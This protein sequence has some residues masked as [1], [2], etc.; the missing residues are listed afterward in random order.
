[1]PVPQRVE[2]V[3]SPPLS[4]GTGPLPDRPG[5]VSLVGAGPGCPDLITVRGLRA[6]AA[7][8]VVL[9]DALLDPSFAGLFPEG[10]LAIPVGKRCGK[11]G[12]EQ[13]DIHRL[14]IE[15]A[16]A[17]RR[18][19]RLK[20]GDPLIFG[21]GGEEALA[22]EAAGIPFDVI[23]GV[24]AL[25]GAAAG[26]GFPL[27][28]REVSRRITVLEGHHLPATA[29]AWRDLAASGGTLA[30]YMG[31]RTLR[32]L[33]RELLDHGAPPTLP[34]ALVEQAQCPGQTSTF[35]TL[36]HAASGALLPATSGPGILFL[37]ESL[38]HR[39]HP[40]QEIPHE[41]AALVPGSPREARAR[42]G[43]RERRAG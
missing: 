25:Q 20:G 10:T 18:V 1:M 24:S 38:H 31:T 33:A 7:A 27:T 37:G 34:V 35:S 30:V 28:H 43:R 29:A 9:Y 39:F 12:T 14:M 40:T 26:A 5:F 22:L 6:L 17:G 13:A 16:R 11:G 19:A 8:E 15:Y 4:A 3:P 2:Q 21:R 42:G 23:P 41:P 32:T 36:A